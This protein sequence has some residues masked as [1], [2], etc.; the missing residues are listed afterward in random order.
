[1]AVTSYRKITRPDTSHHFYY[2]YMVPGVDEY[3]EQNFIIPGLLIDKN[4]LMVNDLEMEL[5]AH[6]SSLD[7]FNQVESDLWLLQNWFQPRQLYCDTY[8]H[9]ISPV[10]VQEGILQFNDFRT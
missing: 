2:M 1:M 5:I 8:N 10:V 3:Y 6:W 4:S 9:I 7:A